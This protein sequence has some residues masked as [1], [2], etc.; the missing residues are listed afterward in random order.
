[1]SGV[2]R[3]L[4]DID[5]GTR[6]ERFVTAVLRQS[7]AV[8]GVFVLG[9]PPL[10]AAVF[11][12]LESWLFLS[13]RASAEIALDERTPGHGFFQTAFYTAGYLVAALPFFAA[14]VGFFAGFVIVPAFP[15]EAW[16]A[17]RSAAIHEPT[18]RAALA[19]LAASIIFDTVR[20]LR[21]GAGRTAEVRLA[22]QREVRLVTVRWIILTAGSLALG[23][24][25]GSVDKARLLVVAIAVAVVLIEALPERFGALLPAPPD[26]EP[27]APAS[28]DACASPRTTAEKAPLAA[29]CVSLRYLIRCGW[30]ASAPSRRCRSAS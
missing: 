16:D 25:A 22:H 24:T 7:I 27:E 13:F 30:S 26:R 28:A 10:D 23:A 4:A 6:S 2:R 12:V 15:A 20:H 8:A 9:W 17:F 3:L 19:L 29:Q 5:A 11:F 18:F 1:M 14:L 21:R